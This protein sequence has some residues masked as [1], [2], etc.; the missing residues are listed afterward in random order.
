MVG[1]LYIKQ[2]KACFKEQAEWVLI[3]VFEDGGGAGGMELEACLTL[4]VLA[5]LVADQ[6]LMNQSV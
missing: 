4:H 5:R 2:A 3:M 1:A 6:E